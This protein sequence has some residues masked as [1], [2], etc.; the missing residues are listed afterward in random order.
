MVAL[1]V[2]VLLLAWALFGLVV[3][4]PWRVIRVVG[5]VLEA[6]VAAI[7]DREPPSAYSRESSV[8]DRSGGDK[9]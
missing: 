3:V 1:E 9:P 4:V 7:T 8:I 2:A 5:G 6:A